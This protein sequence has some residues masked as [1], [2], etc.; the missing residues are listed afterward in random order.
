MIR[1]THTWRIESLDIHSPEHILSEV[2]EAITA[3]ASDDAFA[4]SAQAM[5]DS[6]TNLALNMLAHLNRL[7]LARHFMTEILSRFERDAD[8]SR[9]GLVNAVTSLAR[10][11][12]DPQRRW[13]LESLGGAIAAGADLTRTPYPPP[14]SAPRVLAT[15]ID[16]P[17]PAFQTGR[18]GSATT[19]FTHNPS[20]RVLCP[21]GYPLLR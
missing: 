14:L 8:R 6:R 11:T 19:A 17:S 10:D 7:P 3:C 21:F 4:A 15:S 16:L 12:M 13:D 5:S 2:R 1:S 20:T 9:F 18:C